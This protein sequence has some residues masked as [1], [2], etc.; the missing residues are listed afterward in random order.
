M[1]LSGAEKS[2]DP[3]YDVGDLAVGIEHELVD[4]ADLLV[5]RIVDR[6]TDQLAGPD[7]VVAHMTAR[8][9]GG[10]QRV[11]CRGR[12]RCVGGS[13]GGSRVAWGRGGG[14]RAGASWRSGRGAR[15]SR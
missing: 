3:E 11:R 13:R 5:G 14:R 7:L 8:L 2:A 1:M 6:R 9:C 15:A 4:R 10:R 12:S